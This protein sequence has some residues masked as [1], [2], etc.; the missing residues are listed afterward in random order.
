MLLRRCPSRSFTIVGDRAQARHGFAES[1]QERLARIGLD[2]VTIARLTINYR[3]PTE[4]MAEAEPIIRAVVPDANVPTSIRSSG[5]PVRHANVSEL[6]VLLGEWL[7][8]HAEGVACVI[9]H[10]TFA[11]TS[12]V[13]SLTPQRAKGLEFDLVVLVDPE[14]FGGGIEGAVDRYVAMTRATQQL[15]I[16]ASS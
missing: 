6:A 13:R 3:T 7:A 12:R 15:V 8:G 10:P 5:I 11:G 14:Q 4:V 2:P 9:G 16:L 1:W